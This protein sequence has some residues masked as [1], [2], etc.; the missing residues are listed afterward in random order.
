MIPT[1]FY[2]KSL[3]LESMPQN[4]YYVCPPRKA[5]AIFEKVKEEAKITHEIP[6]DLIR[7][8]LGKP[9]FVMSAFQCDPAY[10]AAR[11]WKITKDILPIKMLDYSGPTYRNEGTNCEGLYRLAEFQRMELVWFGSP[12]MVN[13]IQTKT[14]ETTQNILNDL[15]LDW[16]TEIG[17]DPFYL[18]GRAD[19]RR[20]IELPPDPKYE[21]R[22]TM[23]YKSKPGFK[24]GVSACSFNNHGEHYIDAFQIKTADNTK[25]WTGCTGI[26]ITRI[27]VALFAQK[28]FESKN[29]PKIFQPIVEKFF[30]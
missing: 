8:G 22:I 26:G 13:E 16:W 27:A 10:M 6:Y 30:T 7:S 5:Y 17:D 28:G 19:E 9:S 20:S 21:T 11:K 2:L 25:I 12:E 18:S 29:W 24:A 23:P 14:R 1:D 4:L 3:H 15:E